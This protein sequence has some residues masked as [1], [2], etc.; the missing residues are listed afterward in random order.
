MSSAQQV[1]RLALQTQ[2]PRGRDTQLKR[3]SV[4]SY[5]V[6]AQ[7]KVN[8]PR[9]PYCS[10]H[11]L[12]WNH[13][14]ESLLKEVRDLDADIYCFQDVDKYKSWWLPQLNALGYDSLFSVK[15]SDASIEDE[16][17]IAIFFRRDRFQLFRSEQVSVDDLPPGGEDDSNFGRVTTSNTVALVAALQPWENSDHPS[18]ICVCSAQ[19]CAATSPQ[20]VD[21]QGRQLRAVLKAIAD[22]NQDFDL[23]VVM[24]GS[25]NFTPSGSHYYL[26]TNGNMPPKPL[27]PCKLPSRP[28]A[29]ALSRSQVSQPRVE[30]GGVVLIR[31][32]VY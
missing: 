18:A 22:L 15:G 6:L 14:R 28:V 19:L 26:V 10:A 12:R 25:F 17:G 3:F 20:T 9:F 31:T 7:R 5:N 1:Q 4:V 27:P 16:E 11:A 32:C 23:P 13:R 21:L 30:C 8:K 2:D 24:C 29:E